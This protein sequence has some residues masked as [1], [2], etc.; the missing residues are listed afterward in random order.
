[1]FNVTA[2]FSLQFQTLKGHL[3]ADNSDNCLCSVHACIACLSQDKADKL[4]VICKL[5]AQD[6]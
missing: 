4:Q 6:K 1:M 3:S 2:A 5:V